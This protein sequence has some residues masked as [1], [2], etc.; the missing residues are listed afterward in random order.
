MP[1]SEAGRGDPRPVGGHR[2]QPAAG[3]RGHGHGHHRRDGRAPTPTPSACTAT[4]PAPSIWRRRCATRSTGPASQVAADG[5]PRRALTHAAARPDSCLPA[6]ARS[7]SS[8]AT[9]IDADVNARVHA[10]WRDLL[11]RDASAGVVEIVPT[12]R[13]LLIH[14]DPLRP[15]RAPPSSGSCATPTRSLTSVALPRRAWSRCRRVYGGDAGPDLTDVA[16]HAGL[17]RGR[18]RGDPRRHRLPRLHDGIHA[19]LPVSGRHVA[20]HRDAAAGDAADSRARRFGRDRRRADGHLS[21]RESGRLAADRPDAGALFDRAGRRRPRSSKPAIACGSCRSRQQSTRSRRSIA[22]AASR[23]AR[24]ADTSRRAGHHGPRRRHADD[25]AGPGPVRARSDTACP[26]SGAM[27]AWA[28]R[29]ANRLVGNADG[30]GGPRD[31]A[32]GAGAPVRRRCRDRGDRRRPAPAA[33][34]A[35]IALWQSH[36]R[37]RAGQRAGVRGRAAPACARI[38]PS[39]AASTCPSSSAADRRSPG[40][41]FGGHQGRAL[42]AGD[43]LPIGTMAAPEPNC[44]GAPAAARRA[45]RPRGRV[46]ALRVDPGAAGRCVHAG[47]ARDVP[48]GDLHGRRRSRIG[49]GA[50]WRARA[51][52][53]GPAPTS[54]RTAR[55]SGPSRSRGDG[56]PI[57]LMADRGT[58]GG[59]T[60]IATVISADLGLRRPGG[61]G[62]PGAVRRRRSGAGPRGRTRTRAG[63]RRR[64]T[65]DARGAGHA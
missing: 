19:G 7:S 57:I 58:T 61:P 51:S 43:R 55:R 48:V 34:R 35:A 56:V 40:P 3:D 15:D 33:R 59:Y 31:D 50:A 64:R 30:A 41:R 20:A 14:F 17:S 18:G 45:C 4:R 22:A 63:A 62:R 25:G 44:V 47:G 9:R 39:P 2:A 54:C 6:I 12:Y 26:S 28:L 27:D 29:A 42:R 13:S 24:A 52:R 1:R 11:D 37:L 65:M 10:R 16:A 23:P 53:T 32:G 49:S 5:Q 21:H 36:R 46:H 8:T 60:K 38:S